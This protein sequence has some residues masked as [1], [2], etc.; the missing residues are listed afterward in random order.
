MNCDQV[1][2]RLDAYLEGSLSK[3]ELQQVDRHVDSCVDC[4]EKLRER[5]FIADALAED[6]V[7]EPPRELSGS[8]MQRIRATEESSSS[9]QQGHPR[10]SRRSK[11]WA[12]AAVFLVG[13]LLGLAFQ[14]AVLQSGKRSS[15]RPTGVER[16]SLKVLEIHP[17][18]SLS[19]LVSP[20]TNRSTGGKP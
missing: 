4:T 8:V 17:T 7:P 10:R 14:M 20:N 3:D 18:G 5:R 13:A 6:H 1:R 11:R 2:E 16:Q 19:E 12:A 15:V 9:S